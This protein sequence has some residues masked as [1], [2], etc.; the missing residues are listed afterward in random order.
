MGVTINYDHL[1]LFPKSN[2]VTHIKK[3]KAKTDE[4]LIAPLQSLF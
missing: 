1:I 3:D 4:I 2:S